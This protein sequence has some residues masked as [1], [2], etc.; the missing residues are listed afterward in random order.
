[1]S[2]LRQRRKN[3]DNDGASANE[4]KTKMLS[5]TSSSSASQLEAENDMLRERIAHIRHAKRQE[6]HEIIPNVEEIA[7]HLIGDGPEPEL[8]Q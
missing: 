8:S 7:P 6:M 4:A 1:M 5:E 2:E 3:N